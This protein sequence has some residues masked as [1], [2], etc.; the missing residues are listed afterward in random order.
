MRPKIRMLGESNEKT[1][2]DLAG[3]GMEGGHHG[4]EYGEGA[5]L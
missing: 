3:G 5:S 2:E 1:L 4:R